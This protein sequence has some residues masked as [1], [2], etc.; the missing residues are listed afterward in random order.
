MNLEIQ[1]VVRRLVLGIGPTLTALVSGTRNREDVERW[2]TVGAE[3]DT[4]QTRRL[5]AAYE[6]FITIKD[7]EGED[8]ARAWFLGTNP[9]LEDTPVMA[10]RKGYT[11]RV[12]TVARGFE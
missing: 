6:A 10:L 11:D 12:I 7:R 5:Y 4:E 3:P 9:G 8:V 2:A 1:D